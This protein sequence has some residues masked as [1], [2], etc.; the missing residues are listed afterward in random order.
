ML[1]NFH[2]VGFFHASCGESGCAETEAGG[3]PGTSS[4]AG[5]GIFVGDDADFFERKGSV[6]ATPAT[7]AQINQDEMLVGATSDDVEA[8]IYELMSEDLGV[9]DDLGSVIFESG[10]EGFV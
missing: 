7:R 9:F 3:I 6:L 10:L 1:G 8:S 2:H 5:H 4:L